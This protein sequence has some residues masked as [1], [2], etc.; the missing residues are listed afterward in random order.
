MI[1]EFSIDLESE[2]T[3]LLG[4][5]KIYIPESVVNE[6]EIILE[7]GKGNQKKL[8]TPALHFIKKYP[9]LTHSQF[10]NADDAIVQIASENKKVVV[11]NDKEL[12]IRLKEKNV[13]RIFLRGKQQLV[14][15]H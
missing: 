9:I 6:I 15:E 11:T 3:R 10:D 14:F 7:K 4:S 1:F 8:A 13:P 2:L 12:R 5:H